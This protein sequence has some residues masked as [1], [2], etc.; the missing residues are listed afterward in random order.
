MHSELEWSYVEGTPGARRCVSPVT[1]VTYQMT[2]TPMNHCAWKLT[3]TDAASSLCSPVVYNHNDA[4]RL[5]RI[6]QDYEHDACN[7]RV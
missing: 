2:P 6:A 1:G 3:I 5:Y 4:M 7:G